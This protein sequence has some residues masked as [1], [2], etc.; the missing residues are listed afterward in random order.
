MNMFCKNCGKEVERN[1]V[2]CMGCGCDP[3]N[4]EKFCR[5]CGSALNPGQ[6]VCV[7]CGHAVRRQGEGVSGATGE[8]SKSRTTAALLAIFLGGFGAHEFYLGNS[9]SAII[10]LVVYIVGGVLMCVPSFVLSMISIIEGIIY[11]AKSDEEFNEVYVKGKRAW[12]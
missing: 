8:A 3:L 9:N 5:H 10:R 12:F 11:L 6:V 1:A 2:A 4:G 7:K